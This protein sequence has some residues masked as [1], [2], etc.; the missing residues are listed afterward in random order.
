MKTRQYE[1]ITHL[2]MFH[3]KVI[4]KNFATFTRK[5]PIMVL[6]VQVEGQQDYYKKDFI[7]GVSL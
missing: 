6:L 1:I 4:F 2:E 3:K 5:K 7:A